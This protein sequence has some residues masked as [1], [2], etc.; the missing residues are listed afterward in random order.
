MSCKAYTRK[1]FATLS[2][3]TAAL[4]G[5]DF[6]LAHEVIQTLQ[7]AVTAVQSVNEQI[8]LDTVFNICGHLERHF[9]AQGSSMSCWKACRRL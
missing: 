9:R 8:M 1:C 3:A 7:I 2:N 5:T 4:L 6:G